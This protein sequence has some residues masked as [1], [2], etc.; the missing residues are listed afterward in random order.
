MGLRESFID[1][2]QKGVMNKE[3]EDRLRHHLYSYIKPIFTE[4]ERIVWGLVL[5]LM[6]YD[7]REIKMLLDLKPRRKSLKEYVQ[8]G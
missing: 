2:K 1:D 8:V 6:D 3:R 4:Q 5:C 7:F